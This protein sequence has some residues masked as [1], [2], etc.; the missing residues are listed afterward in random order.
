MGKGERKKKDSEYDPKTVPERVR[1]KLVFP[2]SCCILF[3]LER[4]L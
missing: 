2:F 3:F 4:L 1:E